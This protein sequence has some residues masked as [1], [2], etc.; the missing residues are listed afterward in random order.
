MVVP[1]PYP[2]PARKNFATTG[3]AV[4]YKNELNTG[5]P[6]KEKIEW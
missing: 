2:A 6:T 1:I 5:F 3:V 4:K